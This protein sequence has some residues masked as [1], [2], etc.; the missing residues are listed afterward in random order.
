MKKIFLILLLIVENLLSPVRAAVPAAN[1]QVAGNITPP[2]CIVNGGNDDL[3]YSLGNLS[4]SLTANNNLYLLPAISNLLTVSCDAETY[5]T[6]R[7]T[8]AYENPDMIIIGVDSEPARFTIFNLVN[9][10]DTTQQIGGITFRL[11]SATVDGQE[12]Y[13]SRANDSPDNTSYN[14]VKT[15]QKNVTVGWTSTEKRGVALEE[16]DLLAGKTFATTIVVRNTD[17]RSYILP[18]EIL[19]KNGIDISGR[20][21]FVGKAILTFRFSI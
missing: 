13:I 6:F 9:T 17:N 18:N 21:D 15:L 10:E 4:P 20:T 19:I 16:L 1:I 3:L 5:L 8:D 14:S 12:A 2:T 11:T 7:A